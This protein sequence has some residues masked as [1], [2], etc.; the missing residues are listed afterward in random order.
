MGMQTL[1]KRVGIGVLALA[2]TASLALAAF[3]ET[4]SWEPDAAGWRWKETTGNYTASG[5]VHDGTGWYYLGHDTYMRTGWF[6]DADGKWYFLNPVSNGYLGMMQTGWIYVDG[7]WYF[8]NADGALVDGLI[9]VDGQTYYLNPV[10]DGSYGAMQTGTV[11]IGGVD[12][13]FDASGACVG[14][15][16][17]G[18]VAYTSAGVGGTATGGGTGSSTTGGSGSSSSRPG[19]SSSG[20]SSSGNNSS[21]SSADSCATKAKALMPASVGNVD[22]TKVISGDNVTLYVASNPGDTVGNAITKSEFM[23][24]MGLLD[25]ADVVTL[26][27]LG[28]PMSPANAISAADTW[29]DTHIGD[30]V[31]QLSTRTFTLTFVDNSTATYIFVAV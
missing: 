25:D 29:Y 14:D 28:V 7:V 6:Q 8:A 23:D 31:S 2:V 12:Y 26:T 16:P 11:S 18:A 21:S 13:T 20:G 17:S 27:Y 10:H 22:I 9:Y 5:W 15:A 24:L 3:A 19:G 4:G 1:L 30:D